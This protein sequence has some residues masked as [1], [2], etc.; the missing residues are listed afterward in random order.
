MS[1][2]LIHSVACATVVPSMTIV[3]F[4]LESLS[5]SWRATF[6]IFAVYQPIA[7][8]VY[9]WMKANEQSSRLSQSSHHSS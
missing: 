3:F 7:V 9:A 5:V 8:I 6:L 1:L 4:R 2:R